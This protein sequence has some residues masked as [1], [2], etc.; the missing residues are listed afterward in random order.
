MVTDNC[1]SNM[2]LRIITEDTRAL[3]LRN[4]KMKWYFIG[5][6]LFDHPSGRSASLVSIFVFFI[7]INII[8]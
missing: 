1:N 5:N 6:F 7:E 4:V 8:F 2:F 3:L